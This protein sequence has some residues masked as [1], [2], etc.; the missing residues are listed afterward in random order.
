MVLVSHPFGAVTGENGTEIR[1]LTLPATA[2]LP[3][4]DGMR[5][6][7]GWPVSRIDFSASGTLAYV[8]GEDG[9]LATVAVASAT[10]MTVMDQ[11]MLP[12]AGYTDM[13]VS[14]D[15]TTVY[16]VGFNSTETAGVSQVH[17]SC[18]GML[19]LD[20]AAF[21]NLRLAQA[22][23]AVPGTDLAVVMGGQVQFFEPMDP[24]DMRIF[25][26]KPS[27]VPVATADLWMDDVSTGRMAVSPQ[28]DMVVVT[29]HSLFSSES[30]QARAFMLNG[31]TLSPGPVLMVPNAREALF[32]N[33]GQTLLITRD[34]DN[35]VSYYLRSGGQ[36]TSGGTITGIGLADQMTV[37]RRGMRADTVLLASVDAAVGSEANV[38]VIHVDGP[39]VVS[40][41]GQLDLGVGNQNIPVAI[42]V[43]P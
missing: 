5:L 15:G 40:Y 33:D 37:V 42:A 43:A 31:T 19:T 20:A 39:G 12:S 34:E 18:S 14:E 32:S 16:P 11:V 21:V 22:I 41:L 24:L 9:F 13:L 3:I 27:L 6:D 10:S 25:S 17:V 26:L 2:G 23:V 35:R 36:L 29:N 4:D 38:A 8:L 1:S 30:G 7:V 28:A